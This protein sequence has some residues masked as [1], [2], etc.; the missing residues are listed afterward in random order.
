MQKITLSLVMALLCHAVTAQPVTRQAGA[1]QQDNSMQQTADSAILHDPRLATID[2]AQLSRELEEYHRYMA[3]GP[4]VDA[5]LQPSRIKSFILMHPDYWVSLLEFGELVRSGLIIKPDLKF[6]EFSPGMQH[7]PL[8]KSVMQLIKDEAAKLGPGKAAPDFTA[9]TPEGKP[10]HLSDLRGKWV[11]LDFWASWCGPC[12]MENPNVLANYKKYRDR[13]FAVL[14]FSL[15]ENRP[16]WKGAIQA[17]H[18]EWDHAGDLK[19]WHSAIVQ[20]FMV[21]GVP[22]SYLIDP[23]GKI[24]AVDLRGDELGKML[25]KTIK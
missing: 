17:D 9:E 15:D 6:G 8:G 10:I 19:G 14:S 24:V 11:L 20:S 13:N 4:A 5:S 2:M 1:R 23:E 12:R 16:A 22:K 21:S 25:E 18:M 7:S 3:A